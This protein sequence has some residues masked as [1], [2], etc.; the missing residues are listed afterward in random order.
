MLALMNDTW[1]LA[2]FSLHHY[3]LEYIS[4]ANLTQQYVCSVYTLWFIKTWQYVHL[5][6]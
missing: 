3:L 6:S 4:Q 5:W 2:R 1:T